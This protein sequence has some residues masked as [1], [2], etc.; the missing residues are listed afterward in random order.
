MVLSFLQGLWVDKGLLEISNSVLSCFKK[1]REQLVLHSGD[2]MD[3][4]VPSGS[5]EH[6]I[7]LMLFRVVLAWIIPESG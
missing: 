3:L 1:A 6:I 5:L 7:K 2:Y 4:G